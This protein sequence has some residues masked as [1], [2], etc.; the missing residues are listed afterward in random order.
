MVILEYE[1]YYRVNNSSTSKDQLNLIIS[2]DREYLFR[3][4]E[5]IHFAFQMT[6]VWTNNITKKPKKYKLGEATHLRWE[7]S[8]CTSPEDAFLVDYLF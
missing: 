3:E 4:K 2:V 8:V 5:T 6:I 7:I 1:W